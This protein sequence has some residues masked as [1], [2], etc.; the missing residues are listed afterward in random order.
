MSD[1]ELVP[2]YDER[3]VQEEIEDGA[4]RGQRAPAPS[5]RYRGTGPTEL[6]A[7]VRS[8]AE[9]RLLD[10]PPSITSS[11][12]RTIAKPP[13]GRWRLPVRAEVSSLDTGDITGDISHGA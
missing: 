10:Y 2:N 9:E 4:R 8:S 1:G 3:R 11:W 13:R 6:L 7:E 5:A 12:A